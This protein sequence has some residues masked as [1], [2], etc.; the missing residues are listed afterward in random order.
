VIVSSLIRRLACAVCML[1]LAAGCGDGRLRSAPAAFTVTPANLEFGLTNLSRPK[2][3][4]V[5][6]GNEGRSTLFIESL[7]PSL[8]NVR[9]DI[10]EAFSLTAGETRTVKVTF[11][12]LAEGEVTGSLNVALGANGGD[13]VRQLDVSGRGVRGYV[14]VKTGALDFGNVE[15]DSPLVKDIL[16]ENPTIVASGV[17]FLIQ[18]LDADEFFSSELTKDV[19]LN[20]GEVRRL[21]IAF[22]PARLGAAQA[23]AILDVC[24]GCEKAHVAL[25]GVG[26]ASKLDISPMRLDFG[27][28]A[29]GATAEQKVTIRNLGETPFDYMG[30]TLL[31]NAGEFT[32]KPA[33]ALKNNQLAAGASME[34]TVSF[35]PRIKGAVKGTLLELKLLAPGTSGQGPKL[36][37]S[38]EGGTSCVSISPAL[39]DFGMVP[40]GV[41][42]T[43]AV[44]VENRCPRDV[45]LTGGAI[46][47]TLGGYFSLQGGGGSVFVPS[48][49][50]GEWKV[51]YLPK[52]STPSSTGSLTFKVVDGTAFQAET[53]GLKG[54]SK[55]FSPCSY[56]VAPAALDYGLVSVGSE[57][58]LGVALTNTGVD[59]CYVSSMGLVSGSDAEFTAATAAPGV[60]VPG[61]KA[62][63]PIRFKPRSVGTF[64]GLAE[65]W[66]NHPT[67][68]HVTWTLDGSGITSCFTLQPTSVDFGTTQLTCGAR[69]RS[70][71][72]F[73]ACGGTVQLSSAALTQSTSNELR[74]TGAPV[75]PYDLAPGQ[76]VVFTVEYAPVDDG[77]DLASLAVDAGFGGF[78]T[79]GIRG[80]GFSKSTHTDHF[81]Q[82]SQAKVDVLWVVDNSGSMVEEQTSL[83]QY[84]A[85]FLSAAQANGVDYQIGVTTTGIESITGG[86]YACPGGADGGEAGRLFPVDGTSTRIIT[87]NTPSATEVF[88]HNVQVGLCHWNEQGLEAAYR[89]LSTPLVNTD[90]DPSTSTPNDGNAGFLRQDAKLVLLFVSDEEDFSPESVSFYETF[91]KSLKNNDPALLSVS[92]IVGPEALETCPSANS[93]GSR[94]LS[95]ARSTGGAVDS[96]CTPSWANTLQQ[97]SSSAFEANRRFWLTEAPRSADTLEVRVNGELKTSG[98]SY[99]A[100]NNVI[101]FDSAHVPEV[102]ATIDVTYPLACN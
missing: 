52:K 12:P 78:N 54:S 6:L 81:V 49:Q 3:V 27:R 90:D 14:Q 31:N 96:I 32:V 101:V 2:T 23:E 44:Q 24:S 57:V 88:A 36:P 30:T 51:T 56:S 80:K 67:N 40:E 59:D 15:L 61:A 98:W 68:G 62:V 8:P 55:V 37:M 26:I 102:G 53:V 42:V 39:L 19:V 16:V 9:T 70:V 76:S 69:V 85:A 91:F 97:L 93:S 1:T 7:L 83:A 28:V 66:V 35:T 34:L 77:E 29:L 45:E 18:G 38:G 87:P 5:T 25:S 50:T 22:N 21:P 11:A 82:K 47:T 89:A 46:A 60:V 65:A 72:A 71:T 100:A 64:T 4:E 58:L 41:S 74:L 48:G 79:V 33:P 43:R 20:P 92:A 86:W 13:G 17:S 10:S 63:L 73:N 99:D 94:Y 75:F 84:F 95:L